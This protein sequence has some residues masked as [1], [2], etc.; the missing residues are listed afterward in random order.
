MIVLWLTTFWLTS[1]SAL[2]ADSATAR[3]IWILTIHGTAGWEYT[4][5]KRD[6]YRTEFYQWEYYLAATNGPVD[7]A[8]WNTKSHFGSYAVRPRRVA[9]NSILIQPA[10]T[11]RQRMRLEIQSETT[12]VVVISRAFNSMDFTP[13][14]A[15]TNNGKYTIIDEDFDI[16]VPMSWLPESEPTTNEIR[17]YLVRQHRLH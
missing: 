2:S 12:N 17:F 10:M 16:P 6:S 13:W 11:G 14:M 1:L 9:G 7:I 5:L 15:L 4:L 8:D 3:P